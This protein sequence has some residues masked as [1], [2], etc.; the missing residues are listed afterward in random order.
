[1]HP[2]RSL[3][4][5]TPLACATAQ[6]IAAPHALVREAGGRLRDESVADEALARHACATT[7]R[8]H[9]GLRLHI[10]PGGK[11]SSRVRLWRRWKTTTTAALTAGRHFR[12]NRPRRCRA[13]PS[14]AALAEQQ[15]KRDRGPPAAAAGEPA[16]DR[17]CRLA[18]ERTDLRCRVGELEARRSSGIDR[19]VARPRAPRQWRRCGRPAGARARPRRADQAALARSRVHAGVDNLAWAYK[20]DG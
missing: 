15:R 5:L 20:L 6:A 16:L 1:M 14:L 3:L 18:P 12:G 2:S 13:Q 17:Q 9:A 19:G 8:L 4:A 10:A 7:L 11:P